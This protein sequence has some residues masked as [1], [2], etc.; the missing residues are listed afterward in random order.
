MDNCIE[1]FVDKYRLL[2]DIILIE[3]RDKGG[4]VDDAH[5]ALGIVLK[6][7]GLDLQP[8]ME[9]EEEL[10]EEDNAINQVGSETVARFQTAME[11]HVFRGC[12]ESEGVPAFVADENLAQAHSFL[13]SAVGWIKVKVPPE[14]EEKA[15]EILAAFENGDYA[16]SE[17]DFDDEYGLP[18]EPIEES[19]INDGYSEGYAT[20]D[21]VY[22]TPRMFFGDSENVAKSKVGCLVGSVKLISGILLAL[23]LAGIIINGVKLF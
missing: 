2:E 6:D 16:V 13:V 11:A 17:E 10:D 9:P 21:S 12:L 20:D 15:H 22:R 19:K 4:L 1:L 7:R 14:F 23:V 3:M 5:T 18:D 8:M